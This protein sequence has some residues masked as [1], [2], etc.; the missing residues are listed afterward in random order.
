MPPD[1][2]AAAVERLAGIIQRRANMEVE[3]VPF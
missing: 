1:V 3:H 2:L